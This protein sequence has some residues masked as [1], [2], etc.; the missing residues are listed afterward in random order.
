MQAMHDILERGRDLKSYDHNEFPGVVP[1]TFLGALFISIISYPLHI[2]F[3][4]THLSKF[5]SQYICRM[6]LGLV[7]WISFRS[8]RISVSNKF[9]HRCGILLTLLLCMQFH[10]P[11]YMSRPLP[12]TFALAM[13]MQGYSHW[14]DGR[15]TL[16]LYMMG[17]ASVV[18]R[19]DML[20]ILLPTTLFM[21]ISYEIP[22]WRTLFTG[23]GVVLLSLIMSVL[24]DSILWNR[25]VWPEG[26]VLYFNT[27]LNKSSEW[28]TQPFHWYFSSAIPK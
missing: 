15:P 17:V 23:S 6:A 18:F 7:S 11:F 8:F 5:Y 1:R 9:G 24:I 25:W 4:L 19:C 10:L 3:K 14:L 22:F 20:V 2:L 27:A 21:L 16:C 12:N 28:G 26:E 13:C